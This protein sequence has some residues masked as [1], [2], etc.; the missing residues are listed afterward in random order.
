MEKGSERLF[1]KERREFSSFRTPSARLVLK[2]NYA[3]L[4]RTAKRRRGLRIGEFERRALQAMR[5]EVNQ[6]YAARIA[7]VV[8]RPE[9]ASPT[10][11]PLCVA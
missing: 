9:K 8:T 2:V 1:L 11:F 3:T 7:A 5:D 6:A 4:L 10:R